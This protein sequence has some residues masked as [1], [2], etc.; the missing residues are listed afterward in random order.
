M[1]QR[2]LA[3][4]IMVHILPS[5]SL[6][7]TKTISINELLSTCIDASLR[8]CAE[9]RAV[10]A[11]RQETGSLSQ[12][13]LKDASD[14]RSALT[15]ADGAAQNA[16]VTSLTKEWNH[17]LEIIGEEDDDDKNSSSGKPDATQETTNN[18]KPLRRDLCRDILMDDDSDT[19]LLSDV[20]IWV[21]PLDGTRE[22]VE[23]RVSNC[24]SL[25]GI[26]VKEI[27]I[28]GV[29]A[30][31]FPDGTLSLEP[32]VVYGHVGAGYGVCGTSLM[33]S[34]KSYDHLERPLVAS[35]DSQAPVMVSG[36]AIALECAGGGSSVLYGGAGN[37]ILATA[38][39]HVDCTIQHRFGGPWDTCAPEAVLRAMGGKIT[40]W[41]GDDLTVTHKNAP[42]HV[43]NLGFVATGPNSAIDHDALIAS[44]RESK[45]VQDYLESVKSS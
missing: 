45:V 37:K 2:F 32:T 4:I 35:G 30:I 38:A 27:P 21:D 5:A 39:G 33:K 7:Q 14:S 6:S 43:C 16:I 15:E 11:K 44:L 25:I 26:T 3:V 9:I 20:Q 28:A 1:L 24:Q 13:T 31:P 19:V 34:N 42:H 18:V 22:F 40:T 12:T 36:R 29:M 10:Q 17:E 23:N 8:G 41:T